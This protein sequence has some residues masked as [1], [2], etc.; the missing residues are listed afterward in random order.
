MDELKKIN[1]V[2]KPEN[3]E[4]ICPICGELSQ[5]ISDYDESIL[6]ASQ[7]L[8]SEIKFV[9]AYNTNFWEDIRKLELSRDN[10][11][12]SIKR[13][14]GQVK[15]I[16]RTYLNS[17]TLKNLKDKISYAKGNILLY[18]ETISEGIFKDLNDELITLN[19]QITELEA[20]IGKFNIEKKLS[21]AKN[22][23]NKN[24]NRLALTLDFED[25]FK[26]MNLKFDISNFDL[27]HLVKKYNNEQ[28]I[29]LS[30]MGSGANWVS[31]HIVLFLS[32]LRFFAKEKANSPIPLILFFDQPSQVYF[33]QSISEIPDI[34]EEGELNIKKQTDIMA[35]NNMYKT[36]FDEISNIQDDTG[37]LPQIIIV[38]HVDGK[39]L[40]VKDEFKKFTRHDWRGGKALI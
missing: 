11:V 25:E 7:W 39:E 13:N 4:Y 9:E 23:I 36:I 19:L 34:D 30:E 29:F 15:Q 32:L 6:E 31:C 35:V 21:S 22:D 24:M 18:I 40:D 3:E 16:E 28:K 2:S 12:S 5:K 38:D 26:P 17:E 37:V 10:M 33:P 20:E 1:E 14:Y 8:N 27:F